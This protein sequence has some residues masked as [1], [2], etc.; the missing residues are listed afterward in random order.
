M[1]KI[2]W[3]PHTF[4]DCSTWEYQMIFST[5]F[6]T[7]ESGFVLMKDQDGNEKG[8]HAFGGIGGLK[9]QLYTM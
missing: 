4:G 7:I 3:R 9:Y 2:D 1:G 8:R 6:R 5:D